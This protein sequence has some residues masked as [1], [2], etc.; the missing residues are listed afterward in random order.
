MTKHLQ[1]TKL[2]NR[3]LDL[4]SKVLPDV[5]NKI[6]DQVQK[7]I[8]SLVK[9][10]NLKGY[11]GLYWPLPGEVDLRSLKESLDLPVALPV[12]GGNNNLRYHQ[13]ATNSLEKDIC[14][15]PSPTSQRILKPEEI[16]LLIVPGIAIDQQFFR[17]GY[18]GGF[19]DR[20]R[21]NQDWRS[22]TTFVVLPKVCIS[23][24]PL[25]RDIWDIPFNGWITEEG[26]FYPPTKINKEK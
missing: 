16:S 17:L 6:F 11:I 23:L 9:T 3:Y 12:S 7:K 24:K 22:I 5:E 1:K 13:W 26:C 21:S 18:G 14:G 25:P 4:R 15:I 10:K 8:E 20:L 19:F 2:R